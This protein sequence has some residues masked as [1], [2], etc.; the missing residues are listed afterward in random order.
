MTEGFERCFTSTMETSQS[1][2]EAVFLKQ[3]VPLIAGQQK[4]KAQVNP[5]ITAEDFDHFCRYCRC[6]DAASLD[7]LCQTWI[8]RGIAAETIVDSAITAAAQ[9]FGQAWLDDQCN[10]AEVTQACWQLQLVLQRLSPELETKQGLAGQQISDNHT[11]AQ[12]E[13][14]SRSRPFGLAQ[15]PR[16]LVLAAERGSHRLGL[17]IASSLLRREGLE[18]A[19]GSFSARS[20]FIN[21][22][23]DLEDPRLRLLALSLACSEELKACRALVKQIRRQRPD[24]FI[25]IGGCLISR[26]AS[27]RSLGLK[28]DAVIHGKPAWREILESYN[29][30]Y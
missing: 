19:S 20:P 6:G 5:T 1:S 27:P 18:V 29:I 22:K 26:D 3:V 16:A 24:V 15:K 30:F 21:D 12:L 13:L 17:M 9:G 8:A 25:V 14:A 10:F 28:A 11:Q 7:A 4:L 2:I 23:H